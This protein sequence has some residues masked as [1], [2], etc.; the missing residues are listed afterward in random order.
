M[1]AAAM[2]R[3]SAIGGDPLAA[4]LGEGDPVGGRRAQ[5][6]AKPALPAKPRK[7]RATFHLPEDLMD[8]ARNAVVALSGPPVR[9][10]LADLAENAVRRE[11]ERLREEHNRGK[12]FPRREGELRGGR[13]IRG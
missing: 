12:A 6:E 10:T 11:L 7:V 9:L 1:T 13:P 3:R 5:P 4:L 8:E 2:K